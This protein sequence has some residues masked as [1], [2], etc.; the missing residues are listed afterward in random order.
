M[1]LELWVRDFAII[2]SLHVKLEPG[3]TVLTG[4]TGA[5]KSIIVDAV[6]L[7]LGGRADSDMVR[8][9]AKHAQIE[10]RFNL[11]QHTL[12]RS[13]LERE[14][15]VGDDPDRLLLTREVRTSGRS[16]SRV[17]GRLV[18]LSLL[19]EISAGMVDIH[20][21]SEHLSLKRTREHLFLL[22]KYAELD[23]VRDQFAAHVVRLNQVRSDLNKLVQDERTLAQRVDLLQYQINEINQS[24]LEDGEDNLLE[25]ER[26]RLANAEQLAS[27]AEQARA[28][29]EQE[30]DSVPAVQDSLGHVARSLSALA[31]IDASQVTAA[32]TAN[33]LAALTDELISTLRDYRE[34]IE[35][36]PQRLHDVEE[37]L[38]FIRRL[39]RKYGDTLEQIAQYARDAE[40]ELEN[41]SHSEERIIQLEEEQTE[42]L[43]V[44]GEEGWALSQKR[45]E[46]AERL[47][48]AVVDELESLS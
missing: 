1:L 32:E 14:A 28:M 8:T 2:D 42:L 11:F 43:Q 40:S 47:S 4:E 29:L 26:S 25:E 38:E 33:Q 9:G 13:I 15:L 41:I 24:G 3:M 37:R 34:S 31:R 22:D 16:A 48:K 46:A 35:F 19:R 10:G 7:L 39:K 20:G 17:N 12:A 30:I 27:L 23:A 6:N 18:N 44:I 36:N 45:R 5:G 21:Q